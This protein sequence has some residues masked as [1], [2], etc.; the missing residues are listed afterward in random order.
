MIAG[1]IVTGCVLGVCILGLLLVWILQRTNKYKEMP[2]DQTAPVVLFAISGMMVV[3]LFSLLS[4]L[5]F[6]SKIVY[7]LMMLTL[8]GFY[9]YSLLKATHELGSAQAPTWLKHFWNVQKSFGGGAFGDFANTV[10]VLAGVGAYQLINA[11]EGWFWLG[12]FGAFLAALGGLSLGV[13]YLHPVKESK[14]TP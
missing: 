9:L 10:G 7:A 8:I 12:Q 2:M 14:C 1:F 13:R 5:Y 4:G 11:S 3:V 6:W